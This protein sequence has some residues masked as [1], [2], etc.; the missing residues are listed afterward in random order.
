MTDQPA[1]DAS[2]STL[3]GLSIQPASVVSGSPPAPIGIVVLSAPAPEVGATVELRSDDTASAVVPPDLN[4]PDGGTTGF[5]QIDVRPVA[6]TSAVRISATYQGVTQSAPMIVL[7]PQSDQLARRLEPASASSAMTGS[8]TGSASASTPTEIVTGSAPAIVTAAPAPLEFSA[9]FATVGEPPSPTAQSYRA[10]LLALRPAAPFA[11]TIIALLIYL[12]PL[13]QDLPY[14][15]LWTKAN[16]L[17]VGTVVAV[18]AWFGAAWFITNVVHGTSADQ[19]NVSAY[20]Q[21]CQRL[22][23]ID[24]RLTAAANR[25]QLS[26]AELTAAQRATAIRELVR[27]ELGKPGAR[28]ILGTGYI[29]LWTLVHRAEEALLLVQP[30]DEVG[31]AG[32]YDEMRLQGSDIQNSDQL[33]V[34]LRMAVV[35]LAPATAIYLSQQPPALASGAVTAP[36]LTP[37]QVTDGARLAL[38]DVRQAI[39]EFRD[40]SW[41]AL[42]RARNHLLGTMTATGIV[43]YL[44]FA[45]AIGGRAADG[46]S[47]LLTDTF[48]AA[49]SFYLIGATVGLF[50]RLYAESSTDNSVEDYGLTAARIALTPVLSG[51]AALGGVIVVAMLPSALSGNILTPTTATAAAANAV[52]TL[53][54][55][56][57][58]AGNPLGIILSAIFG[59][60]PSL[61]IGALQNAGDKY[62]SAVQSTAAAGTQTH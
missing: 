2:P 44:I 23:D 43:T 53:D 37:E 27:A 45:V 18:L 25:D 31:A 39:N 21:V 26:A 54:Q 41:D 38:R 50:N 15:M 20:T 49:A 40:S 61:L 5:F 60:T 24:A 52:P 3:A 10:A 17:V 4:I 32:L 57:S 16:P 35:R 51:L 19:A 1:T 13:H 55:I 58:L 36:A 7:P 9:D 6:N 42:V 11:A 30:P 47:S 12:A 8:I 48:A 22:R 56:Y 34:K 59:L 14:W 28:W 62:R 29:N 33:L 46:P